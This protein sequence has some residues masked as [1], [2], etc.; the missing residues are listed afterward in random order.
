MKNLTSIL[1]WIPVSILCISGLSCKKTNQLPELTTL[2]V[3]QIF[4][5]SLLGGGNVISEGASPIIEKGVCWSLGQ[6]PTIEDKRTS[7]GYGT[8]EFKSYITGFS[9]NAT[10]FFRAY[11]T[12]AEGTAYGEQV[13]FQVN[14]MYPEFHTKVTNITNTAATISVETTCD[15][16]LNIYASG[17][18]YGT[19]PDLKYG[20][21]IT[22]LNTGI[23]KSFS[24]DIQNLT[25]ATIYYYRPFLIFRL[26]GT[27]N[28][29]LI[30]GTTL[31]FKTDG[32]PVVKTLSIN[33]QFD[34]W[35][36]IAGEV[37][38]NAVTARGICLAQG[39]TPTT[40]DIVVMPTG[41]QESFK[42]IFNNLQPDKT[43]SAR[44]FAVSANGTS[45]GEELTFTTCTG[46]VTDVSGN[47]YPTKLIGTQLWM[48]ENLRTTKFNDNTVISKVWDPYEWRNISYEAY[49]I[50]N[51]ELSSPNGNLYNWYAVG[52]GKLCP[53]GWHVPNKTEITTLLE[54]MH[55][56]PAELTNAV[57]FKAVFGG[58][59]DYYDG[60][61]DN[62]GSIGYWWSSTVVSPNVFGWS[63]N[64][65]QVETSTF[66]RGNGFSV[67]CIKN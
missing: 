60:S 56:S 6:N 31:F 10:Y 39:H 9:T 67:R 42:C 35:A 65:R 63:V 47:T 27:T 21:D 25:P 12:N 43:Y 20:V 51:N 17:F 46:T 62:S 54:L 28:I 66:N 34:T 48:Q 45:Y 2:P 8:G 58:C 37:K 15:N 57:G 38:S 13:S 4:L 53:A 19:N 14:P 55:S 41:T 22:Q 59:R 50:Y 30:Y 18:C 23:V 11:A 33:S 26:Y 52:T 36:E 32:L 61:Y 1:I 7:D 49:S 29:Y 5:D 3:S 24:L 64:S 16:A 40:D 44:T